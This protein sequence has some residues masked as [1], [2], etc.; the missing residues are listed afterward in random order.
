RLGSE[1]R[2]AGH[3]Q[4]VRLHQSRSQIG[5]PSTSRGEQKNRAKEGRYMQSQIIQSRF[6]LLGLLVIMLA[7][8]VSAQPQAA[9][10]PDAGQQE[11][12]QVTK[13][14]GDKPELKDLRS[15]VDKLNQMD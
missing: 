7:S 11:V 1:K 2:R 12:K 6:Y 4:A 14:E 9:S 3:P 10:T 13:P 8:V 15:Q 5:H